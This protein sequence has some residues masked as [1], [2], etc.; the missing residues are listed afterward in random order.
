MA[1]FGFLC[2]SQNELQTNIGPGVLNGGNKFARQFFNAQ[3]IP[4][5]VLRAISR[6]NTVLAISTGLL[7]NLESTGPFAL[8]NSANI[9]GIKPGCKA[10]KHTCRGRNEVSNKY[11]YIQVIFGIFNENFN[12][13][14]STSWHT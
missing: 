12:D 4:G 6:F 1:F 11:R 3:L 2:K 8:S 5:Q 14:F 9:L 13:P 10:H 7:G